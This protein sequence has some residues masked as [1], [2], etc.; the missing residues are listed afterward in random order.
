MDD[1]GTSAPGEENYSIDKLEEDATVDSIPK[2]VADDLDEVCAN[3]SLIPSWEKKTTEKNVF[4]K[5][6]CSLFCLDLP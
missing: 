6:F 1:D 3:N 4:Y 5:N 2:V